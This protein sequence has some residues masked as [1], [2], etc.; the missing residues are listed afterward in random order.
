MKNN[1]I[2]SK[3]RTGIFFEKPEQKLGIETGKQI[4]D[5]CN[6]GAG[7]SSLDEVLANGLMILFPFRIYSP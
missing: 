4:S 5:W 3:D 6:N 2:A 1:A 7:L